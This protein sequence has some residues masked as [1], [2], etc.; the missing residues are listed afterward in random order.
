[1]PYYEKISFGG[2]PSASRMACAFLYYVVLFSR[3][4]GRPVR[5]LFV[6]RDSSLSYAVLRKNL[7]RGNLR[8]LGWPALFCITWFCSPAW[9]AVRL[10]RRFPDGV[11]RSASPCSFAMGGRPVISEIPGRNF[12]DGFSK[13]WTVWGHSMGFPVLP[14]SEI[15]GRNFPDG[16]SKHWTVWGHSMGHCRS[17]LKASPAAPHTR[18]WSI[19]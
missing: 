14:P 8:R 15:P 1:M 12:P 17:R 11:S 10:S 16:F 3:L 4:G 19:T 7:F 5:A 9:G 6:L 13:H 2:I 18:I